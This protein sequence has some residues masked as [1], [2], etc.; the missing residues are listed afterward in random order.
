MTNHAGED[1]GVAEVFDFFTAI[2]K[3]GLYAFSNEPNYN[4][5]GFH[6]FKPYSIEYSFVRPASLFLE[7][8]PKLSTEQPC[9]LLKL[10]P[11]LGFR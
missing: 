5:P 11:K 8:E 2:E 9:S 3:A 4:P 1:S 7:T 6:G 10:L